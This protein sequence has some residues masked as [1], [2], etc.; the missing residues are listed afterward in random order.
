MSKPYRKLKFLLIFIAVVL[1]GVA[2]GKRSSLVKHSSSIFQ[3]LSHQANQP[4]IGN[5]VISKGR[6]YEVSIPSEQ[7]TQYLLVEHISA[8]Y[9]LWIPDTAKTIRGVIVR[10]HGCGEPASATGLD[11]ASDLQWQVLAEKYQFALLGTKLTVN[12]K[13]CEDWALINNGSKTIFL[14]AL[15]A[16]ADKSQQPELEQ[17]PWVLWGHSGGAD[18]IAQMLQEFPDRT[19]AIVGVR[20]GGFEFYGSN[21]ALVG[22][23]VLFSLGA[24]DPYAAETIKLPQQAFSRYRKISAPWTFAIEP[25][26]AHETGN[27]RF[28]AIPYLDAVI[29]ERLNSKGEL[30]A[31]D[32]E[33]GWLGNLTTHEIS[34]ASTYIGNPLEAT[35]LPNEEV[36]RKW[37]EY[38]TTGNVLPTRKPNAPTNVQVLKKPDKQAVITWNFT[39]DLENGLPPFHIYRNSSLVATVKGQ[40]HG[41]GDAP[42]PV[43][44]FREYV[45]KNTQDTAS[46][47]VAAFNEIGESI[48]PPTNFSK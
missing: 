7:S 21:P 33:K 31:I 45:D 34:S 11:H 36:A 17:A 1:L 23:P 9:R 39:P 32:G 29:A 6:Y 40:E 41:F 35:W 15:H 30:V 44:V 12:D 16:L 10:Q 22:I 13:P 28:L 8:N 18:W 5:R 48:S 14:N 25:N 2:W 4:V 20:G 27:S 46:Y 24:K 47:S 26:A 38:V 43:N 42:D 3:P 37:K 19:I